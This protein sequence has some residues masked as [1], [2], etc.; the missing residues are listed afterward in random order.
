MDAAR[1]AYE[2]SIQP[3]VQSLLGGVDRMEFRVE[4]DLSAVL[5]HDK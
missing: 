5:R 4:G 1:R 3:T 2:F